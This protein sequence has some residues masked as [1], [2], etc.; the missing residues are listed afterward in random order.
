MTIWDVIGLALLA[1]TALVLRSA[2]RILSRLHGCPT[3]TTGSTA[4]ITTKLDMILNKENQLMSLGQDVLDAVT[5]E[6]TL[7]DS[8]ITFV[9]GLVANNTIPPDV[10]DAI[11][12]KIKEGSDKLEAALAA[13]VPPP[14]P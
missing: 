6:T 13:N 1:W 5:A 14:T 2:S 10:A 12:A 3:W 8:F 7:I 11:K 9:N 4:T